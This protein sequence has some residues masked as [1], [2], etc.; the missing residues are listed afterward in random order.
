MMSA[1]STVSLVARKLIPMPL[2]NVLRPY[3][4]RIV[5]GS[6]EKIR[7][8]EIAKLG[9]EKRWG[10]FHD[11]EI[12]FWDRVLDV[13]NVDTALWPETRFLRTHPGLLLQGYL[14]KLIDVPDGSPVEILDVGAGPLTTLG[15]KWPGHEV[16]I[17]AVDANAAAYDL[18]LARQGIEPLFRTVPGCAEELSSVVPASSFD[19]VHARNSIDHTK[20]PLKAIR[21]MVSVVKPGRYVFL[22]HKIS[23]GRVEKYTEYHQWNFFPQRSRFY[24]E[25]P[26]M[27]PVDVGGKTLKGIADVTV[28]PSP[29]GPGWF[30]VTI[31]RLTQ[32]GKNLQ[33]RGSS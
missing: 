10:R 4:Q 19:L 6:D 30:S 26:G 1:K 22:N 12:D 7:V 23:E 16:H 2:R 33:P 20:D 13:R 14:T 25:R 18:L 11:E 29:D 21:E 31:K 32:S 24:I 15:K 5:V 28:G 3:W 9:P 8:R 17:T 27:R